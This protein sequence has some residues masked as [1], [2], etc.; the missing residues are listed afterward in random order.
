V[1][2]AA[3]VF[4]AVEI[5]TRTVEG[6]IH[7]YTWTAARRR[8]KQLAQ[9]LQQL[10]L[11]D[12][13]AV[14]TIAWN[15]HRHLELYY[16]VSGMGAAVHTVNPRLHPTQLVY[17]LNHAQDRALFV[18]L[19]FLPLV[20]A[21][22]DKLESVRHLVIL[23][24]PAHMPHGKVPGALCYE[25]LLAAQD[26]SYEW[27]TFDEHRFGD[28]LSGR[29]E[30]QGGGVF[31]PLVR[32]SVPALPGALLWQARRCSHRSHVPR[33]RGVPN[34]MWLNSSCPGAARR[35]EAANS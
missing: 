8:S 25:D 26:G 28:L 34:A 6:P 7:R 19:T 22:W 5:V 35:C 13:D 2:H 20:E 27:P 21:I 17:V 32:A 15:T 24:E 9:A 11:R 14:G 31:P 3:D 33:Q 18:D 23:T 10:Q 12:G 30:S 16:G 29:R 1:E 4:G